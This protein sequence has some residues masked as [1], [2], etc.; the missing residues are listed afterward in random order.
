MKLIVIKRDIPIKNNIGL[1][2]DL[3]KLLNKNGYQIVY[4]NDEVLLEKR[5]KFPKK[6]SRSLYLDLFIPIRRIT[7]I[8]IKNRGDKTLRLK[9]DAKFYLLVSFLFGIV[10]PFAINKGFEFNMIEYLLVSIGITFLVFFI[11]V[12]T[13][14]NELLMKIKD[15][16]EQ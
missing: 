4:A 12:I 9:M 14:K 2:G 3:I 8:E 10:F 11:G 5:L 15:L 13:A 1:K 7:L 6:G 16:I